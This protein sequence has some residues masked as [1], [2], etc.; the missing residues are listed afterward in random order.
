M[1]ISCQGP[2]VMWAQGLLATT[3]Q[4]PPLV[5]G[6]STLL[7]CAHQSVPAIPAPRKLSTT[8]MTPYA[9]PV[10]VLSCIFWYTDDSAEMLPPPVD[11]EIDAER[12]PSLVNRRLIG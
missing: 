7:R 4:P 11:D 10:E 2:T 12:C 8:S 3:S 1:G 6:S 9:G 5:Q